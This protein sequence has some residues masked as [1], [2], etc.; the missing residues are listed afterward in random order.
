MTE[1]DSNRPTGGPAWEERWPPVSYW[2]KVGLALISAVVALRLLGILQGILLV[3]LASFVLAIGFQPAIQWF[4]QRGMRRGLGLGLVLMGSLA[5]AGGMMA[6]VLPLIFTQ[7]GELADRLPAYLED[8]QAGDGV[9]GRL[10]GLVDVSGLTEEASSDPQT[11]LGI[12]GD[13]TSFAFNLL[14]ILL[15]T[16]YFAMS[17]PDIK[18]WAIRL[19]R[20]RHRERF[21]FVV[22]QSS[23]LM[24]NFIVGNLVISLIAGAVTFVGLRLIGV[25]YALAL[26]A[27]VAITDLIPVLGALLGAAGVAAVAFSVG[28][29]ELI[30]SMVLL[31]AY[32][33]VENYLIAP[34]VMK[35]AVDLS[36]AAVI[37]ALMVGGTLAGL[38]GALLA[39]PL[40]ALIK[41]LVDEYIISERAAK[42]RDEVTL[43]N[44]RRRRR[45][46]SRSRPLP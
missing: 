21:V 17:M 14:T 25:P 31:V 46:G 8:L 11:T 38:V 37:I 43:P 28:P 9:L 45:Q 32:Q 22:N 34:R 2:I 13:L 16:P 26:A 23:E 27:W 3:I 10:A 4:E 7:V 19:I 44:E 30:W 1:N 33:Q 18:R 12:L 5:I 35:R 40:A 41:I 20:P 6:L 42:V 24:A 36:P 29:T 15:V 39:L